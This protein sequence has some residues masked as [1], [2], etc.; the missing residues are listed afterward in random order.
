MPT[1][2]YRIGGSH[3]RLNIALPCARYRSL[4]G[5]IHHHTQQRG[6]VKPVSAAADYGLAAG[7]T[8]RPTDGGVRPAAVDNEVMALGLSR[9]GIANGLFQRLVVGALP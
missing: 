3:G 8:H 7:Q 6:R 5:D 1:S 4:T 2:R 9:D